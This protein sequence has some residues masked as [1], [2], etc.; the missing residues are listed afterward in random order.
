MKDVLDKIPITCYKCGK[1]QFA[2]QGQV[3]ECAC[4]SMTYTGFVTP[5]LAYI[6][7]LESLVTTLKEQ[8]AALK[9]DAR[10]MAEGMLEAHSKIPCGPVG[11]TCEACEIARK[12]I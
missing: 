5:S 3:Q 7:S 2:N 6:N 4:G 10:I 12:Y 9:E 8:L 11:N 1:Q